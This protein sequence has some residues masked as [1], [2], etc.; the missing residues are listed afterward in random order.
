M[1]MANTLIYFDFL[2]KKANIRGFKKKYI[3][4]WISLTQ[5]IFLHLGFYNMFVNSKRCWS[6]F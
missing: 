6:I 3:L 4:T 1:H 5:I 2:I